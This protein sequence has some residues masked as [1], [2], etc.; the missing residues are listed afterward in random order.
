MPHYIF[1]LSGELRQNFIYYLFSLSFIEPIRDCVRKIIF[2]ESSQFSKPYRNWL[3]KE[4]VHVINQSQSLLDGLVVLVGIIK[5]FCL[6][7]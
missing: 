1:N 7:V 6:V 5:C 4:T 3:D 2:C